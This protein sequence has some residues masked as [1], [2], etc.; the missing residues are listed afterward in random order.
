MKLSPS[1]ARWKRSN[2]SLR[3]GHGLSINTIRGIAYRFAAKAR[4]SN[5]PA[6]STGERAARRRVVVSTDGGRLRIRTTKRGPKT[7]KGRNR[8]RTDWREPKLLR[9]VDV[10]KESLRLHLQSREEAGNPEFGPI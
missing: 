6:N 5:V 8:Y 9:V 4:L 2:N 10:K 1:W 7:A 3:A